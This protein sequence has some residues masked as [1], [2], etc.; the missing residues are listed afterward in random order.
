MSLPK[1]KIQHY[2]AYTIPPI[3]CTATTV[4]TDMEHEISIAGLVNKAILSPRDNLSL[5]LW[6][7]SLINIKQSQFRDTEFGEYNDVLALSVKSETALSE[8]FTDVE[9]TEFRIPI[10]SELRQAQLMNI[11]KR[12]FCVSADIEKITADSYNQIYDPEEFVPP[13][14]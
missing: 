10:E 3:Q 11:P 4:V 12:G 9:L 8:G 2:N 6:L 5:F 13:D 14:I 1:P 7:S